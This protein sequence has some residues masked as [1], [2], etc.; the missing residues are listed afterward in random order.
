MG[1][2]AIYPDLAGQVALVTGGSKGIGAATCRA[3]AANGVR[4]AV[5]ARASGPVE[6]LVGELRDAGAEAIGVSADCSAQS[7]LE[8]VAHE[9]ESALGPVDLLVPFAGGFERFTPVAE[10]TVEEW[11][12]V[13]DANLT[14]TFIAVRTFL[15]GML[16]RGRGSIVTMSSVSGRFLDKTTQAA[17]A[18]SK[19]GVIMFT[20]H[21]AIEVGPAGIRANCIAPATTASE[22]ISRVM[23]SASTERTA[24]MS[25]LGRLGAP[26]DSANATL[27]LLSA[28]ASWLT[29]VTIDVAGGRVML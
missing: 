13:I 8:R 5:V 23:D 12:E 25:P 2:V 27:F 9:V 24:A 20:R 18:A 1:P 7:E 22:R 3:L 4:V 11:R 28:A 29:G 10:M 17:Y 16:A 26:Q 19:A 15:P 21:L 14:S 6:E